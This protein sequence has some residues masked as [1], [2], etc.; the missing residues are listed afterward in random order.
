MGES[1]AVM[2]G[3]VGVAKWK[4][5]GKK[6]VC[7]ISSMHN[8][9]DKSTVLRTN[10]E[11]KREPVSCPTSVKD[12][13][14]YMGGVDRFDQLHSQYNIAWKSRRWWLKIFYYCIDACIVNSYTVY[15]NT[16]KNCHPNTKPLS[17]LKFRSNLASELIG[18]YCGRKKKG[19]ATHTGKARKRNNPDGRHTIEN[20]TRLTNVG[21]HLPAKGPTFR[22]CANCSTSKQQKR[23]TTVCIQCD[24]ALCIE[25]FIPFHRTK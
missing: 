20:A 7:V 15:K 2:A 17:Q 10:K 22:R 25:C 21:D 12:Y 8:A 5:R 4:D 23:S 13:N 24:V 16:M 14:I 18:S 9:Q 6:C 1:D 3:D 19:P 11:G